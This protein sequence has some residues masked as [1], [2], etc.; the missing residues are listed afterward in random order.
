MIV[1]KDNKWVERL[2]KR[3]GKIHQNFKYI[4][5]D[6]LSLN[7]GVSETYNCTAMYSKLFNMGYIV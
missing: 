3:F 5:S 7:L 4:Q 2:R 1:L 6:T